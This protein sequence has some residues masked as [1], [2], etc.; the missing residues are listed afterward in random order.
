MRDV[1]SILESKRERKWD[2]RGHQKGQTGWERHRHREG[3][4]GVVLGWGLLSVDD[5]YHWSLLHC[6][7][8]CWTWSGWDCEITCCSR[9]RHWGQRSRVDQK[10]LLLCQRD[11]VLLTGT[12][13]ACFSRDTF[14][15]ESIT[16]TELEFKD[17]S[18]PSTAMPLFSVP[19]YKCN[20]L[21]KIK[22][23]SQ[24]ITLQDSFP[25]CCKLEMICK[26]SLSVKTFMVTGFGWSALIGPDSVWEISVSGFF[27]HTSVQTDLEDSLKL[28]KIL[29]S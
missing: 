2:G 18:L 19:L 21:Y 8:Q 14:E 5:G 9:T 20:T 15:I 28:L 24:F 1:R 22:H 11:A 25:L 6:G 26:P 4:S 3:I 7:I 13:S 10:L 17:L 12:L 29:C 27:T 16:M 23:L